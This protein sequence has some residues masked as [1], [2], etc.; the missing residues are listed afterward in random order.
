MAARKKRLRMFAGPNGSGKSMLIKELSDSGIS[1]GPVINADVIYEEITKRGYFD[2]KDFGLDSLSQE[3]WNH[4][5][6][7]IEEIK[8]RVFGS[9]ALIPITISDGILLCNAE[10]MNSYTSALIA[11]F[12]RH[13]ML[14]TGKTFSFETV[15]SHTSKI[16]FLSVAKSSGYTTYLYF[17]ATEDSSININRVENR[18]KKGGHDVPVDKIKA[19]YY[20]SLGLLLP[21]L[22]AADRAYV[23][24]NSRQGN[25]IIMEKGYD[26]R[27]K[28]QTDTIPVWFSQII[29]SS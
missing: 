3:S 26:S 11:D 13:M 6:Q 24:D 23:I 22:R 27:A 5:V 2:L 16:D 17:I 8:S 25:Y 28:F 21:A 7:H 9:N 14:K 1:L 10:K 20:K 18:V 15:M 19:R 4:A 29:F 12:L